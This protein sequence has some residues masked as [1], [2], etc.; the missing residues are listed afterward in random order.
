MLRTCEEVRGQLRSFSPSIMWVLQTELK[1][2][3]LAMVGPLPTES[4]H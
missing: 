3:G 1:S 2:S 4:S